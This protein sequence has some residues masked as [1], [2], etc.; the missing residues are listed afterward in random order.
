MSDVYTDV[1]AAERFAR[2]H[3]ENLRYDHARKRWLVWK[4]HRWVPDADA[5]VLRTATTFARTWQH[6]VAHID[7]NDTRTRAFKVAMRL[8][9]NGY[10][11]R[12]LDTARNFLPITHA[13]KDWDRD[14]MLLGAPNGVIDLRT[15][16]LRA[17]LREDGITL[18]TRAPFEPDATCP[19][20]LAFIEQIF[21]D[22]P[23]LVSY[24]H[25]A[26]GYSVTGDVSE[27]SI[28]FRTGLDQT[29]SRP[30]CKRCNTSSATTHTMPFSTMEAPG[31]GAIPNDR[32]RSSGGDSSARPRR[33]R[34]R[35]ST[36][37]A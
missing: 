22:D 13:G 29:E 17:G 34:E 14:P 3:G 35:L 37:R 2:L 36:K 5:L 21:S 1:G 6:E 33:T 31:R 9:Q 24:V 4:L 23:A 27:Q 15:G 18:S 28:F 32:R 19:R 16:K 25:R 11:G 30:S 8:D 20:W 10:L 7:D 12:L 26:V